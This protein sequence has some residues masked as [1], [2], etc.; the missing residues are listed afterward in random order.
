VYVGSERHGAAALESNPKKI[1]V[2]Q[3]G[4]TAAGAFLTLP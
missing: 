2:N 3:S 4:A 1:A